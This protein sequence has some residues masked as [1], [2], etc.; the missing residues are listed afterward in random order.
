MRKEAESKQREAGYEEEEE[1]EEEAAGKIR[2]AS[3]QSDNQTLR[4]C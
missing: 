3:N 4:S 1:E 2:G